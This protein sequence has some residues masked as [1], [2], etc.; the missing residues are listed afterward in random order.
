MKKKNYFVSYT[1]YIQ[2]DIYETDEEVNG[3]SVF[4]TFSQAKSRLIK[5][6]KSE[7]EEIKYRIEQVKDKTKENNF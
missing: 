5:I 2:N 7:M 3:T 4:K 6:L 1:D